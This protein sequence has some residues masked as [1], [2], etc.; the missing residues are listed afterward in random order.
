MTQQTDNY[1][2]DR[3]ITRGGRSQDV[4]VTLLLQYSVGLLSL[5]LFTLGVWIIKIIILRLI[6]RHV[7][8]DIVQ[9]SDVNLSSS[10]CG[11]MR[12]WKHGRR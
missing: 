4:A 2:G 12:C 3:Y 8:H 5:S 6:Q 7:P 10:V 11:S 9:S 1:R